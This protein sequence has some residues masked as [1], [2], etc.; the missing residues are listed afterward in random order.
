[1]NVIFRF[2][3]NAEIAPYVPG[4]N[5]TFF[6]PIDSAF[7]KRGLGHLTEEDLMTN[8]AKN[9]LLNFF[10]KGRL[11]NRDLQNDEVFE[12]IGGCGLKIQHL[13]SGKF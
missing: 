8:N 3:N 6:V 1:M 10:I 7:I 12:S 2:L 4:S 9:F 11:Y 5:Y 13:A